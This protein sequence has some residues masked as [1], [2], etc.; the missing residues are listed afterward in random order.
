MQN[1]IVT[2]LRNVLSGPVDTEAMAVY[3]LCET[4]K[5]LDYEDPSPSR[6]PTP[7][8]MFCHWALHVDL[9]RR[10]TTEEFVKRVDNV[11]THFI[12]EQER[13]TQSAFAAEQALI[14]EFASFD[15]FRSELQAFLSRHGLPTYL[16][17]EHIKWFSFLEAY[18]GVIEDGSLF[19]SRLNTV[20]GVTFIKR[21]SEM[22]P[23][24]LP[25][26]PTWIVHLKTSHNGHSKV[27][28]SAQSSAGTLAWGH[29]FCN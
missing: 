20:E 5:L 28:V 1:S 23:S 13:F 2:K 16:C 26:K 19:C 21:S 22:T 4:R 15:K 11:V 12:N 7:L 9:D 25:F 10:G 6:T 14:A 29:R 27:E 24:D 8:R 3:L 18:A 17:D